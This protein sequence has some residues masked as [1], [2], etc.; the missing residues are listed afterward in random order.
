MTLSK[1]P[2]LKRW[3][4]AAI[5]ALG[6][7]L[8]ASPFALAFWREIGSRSLDFVCSGALVIALAVYALRR[9]SLWS[10]WALFI[11]GLW[12]I[13]SPWLLG[14]AFSRPALGDSV[15]AGAGV[16]LLAVWVILLYSPDPYRR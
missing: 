6:A 16:A 13:G 9:R 2:T 12:M 15:A 3:Q 14:F 1:Q 8:M 4:D 10:D 7:W 5:L 11:V